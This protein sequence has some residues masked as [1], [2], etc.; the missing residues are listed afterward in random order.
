MVLPDGQS[1]T[2]DRVVCSIVF[3]CSAVKL[4]D[5]DAISTVISATL[6]PYD[7][8]EDVAEIAASAAALTALPFLTTTR[9]AICVQL[10]LKYGGCKSCSDHPNV[11]SRFA[12]LVEFI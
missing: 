1:V 2:R 4:V 11:E 9:E 3:A 8:G 12:S 5:C 10:S 6:T 7:V